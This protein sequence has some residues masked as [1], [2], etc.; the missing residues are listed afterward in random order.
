[1]T[2]ATRWSHD[3]N[4]WQQKITRFPYKYV[5]HH[6]YRIM[7]ENSE[8]WTEP[9]MKFIQIDFL[10][11]EIPDYPNS[12]KGSDSGKE[13]TTE[14]QEAITQDI[15]NSSSK[16]NKRT[17]SPPT[18]KET[19]PMYHTPTIPINNTMNQLNLN[20][21]QPT[22]FTQAPPLILHSAT[23]TI[24][25][26]MAMAGPSQRSGGRG[27]GGGGGGNF[28]GRGR[29][30]EGEGEGGGRG[31]GGQPA[32]V[33]VAAAPNP[34]RNGLKEVPPTIFQG[35]IKHFDTFKQEWC[36]YQ[37]ANMNH[38]DITVPYN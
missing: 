14:E 10:N 18:Q 35:D 17:L 23:A 34:P 11:N 29:G 6:W 8:Y 25:S 15:V 30:G 32:A 36:L 28:R 12:N 13:T 26:Q 21:T 22:N 5:N 33:A 1:M 27:G 7:W 4:Q 9:S 2:L 16:S 24:A 3:K 31:S 19:E 20:I 37:A 38:N